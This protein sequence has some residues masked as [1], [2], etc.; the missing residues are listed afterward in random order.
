MTVLP[1]LSRVSR[2]RLEADRSEAGGA[3]LAI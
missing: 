3:E 1:G 2:R